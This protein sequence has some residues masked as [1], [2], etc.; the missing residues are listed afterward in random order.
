MSEVVPTRCVDWSLNTDSESGKLFLWHN[1]YNI[2]VWSNTLGLS[3]PYDGL[4]DTSVWE[5]FLQFQ[6]ST[7]Y[8]LC[9]VCRKPEGNEDLKVCCY[10]GQAVHK[11]CS[12]KAASDQIEWKDANKKFVSHM[13]VC[14]SC[15]GVEVPAAFTPPVREAPDARRVVR[16]ALVVRDEYPE[17]V[18]RELESLEKKAC[19]PHSKEED[20]RLLG[21]VCRAVTRFFQPRNSLHLFA[22][23]RQESKGGVGVVALKNIP[24]LTIVGVYPGYC[25]ALSGEHAKLGRPTAK[26]ALMDLNCADYFNVV[27]EEFQSTFTPFINE[28]GEDERSNCGWIQETKNKDGR[29][30]VMTC[31]GIRKGEEL[32]IGYG[33]VYPRSYPYT[34]D[35]FTFHQVESK[36]CAVC[37]ALWHWP[38]TDAEDAVLECHVGYDSATDSYHLV[39]IE[40]DSKRS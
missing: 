15:D 3:E 17:E 29:L 5:A 18:V 1:I 21:M 28:P 35:A 11:L 13:R 19:R 20:D 30:S 4:D 34:Y 38:T 37:F 22:K 23:V 2:S 27:F 36:N 10:C 6:I 40:D 12:T 8:K 26:Y 16:R 9:G 32:L 31:R 7:V 25:D 33:P 39:D 14:G 24:A